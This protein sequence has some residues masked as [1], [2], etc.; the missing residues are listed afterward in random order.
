[1]EQF[2]PNAFMYAEGEE[3][4]EEERQALRQSIEEDQLS[5]DQIEKGEKEAVAAEFPDEGAEV[6]SP[7]GPEAASPTAEVTSQDQ[8]YWWED[9]YDVGDAARNIAQGAVAGQLGALDFA[10]D[11][12]NLIPGVDLPKVPRF[13]NEATQMTR[14]LASFIVPGFIGGGVLPS[15]IKGSAVVKGSKILNNPFTKVVGTMALD[16][17]AGAAIDYTNTLSAEGDNAS[18]MAKKFLQEYYPPAASLIPDNIAT[19]DTDSADDRKR[20]SV[21]E[22]MGLGGAAYFVSGLG[23]LA[24]GASMRVNGNIPEPNFG[25]IVGDSESSQATLDSMRSFPS[26]EATREYYIRNRAESAAKANPNLSPEEIRQTYEEAWSTLSPEI[27]KK[28]SE[29]AAKNDP[30]FVVENLAARQEEALDEVGSYNFSKAQNL[31]EPIFGVHDLY[32]YRESGILTTDELGIISASVDL[33]KVVRNI[34]SVDGSMG[35]V[36]SEA[37]IKYAIAPDAPED[38]QE[39]ILRGLTEQM[40]DVGEYSYIS[41]TGEKITYAE[42]VDDG[43]RLAGQYLGEDIADLQAKFAPMLQAMD[44]YGVRQLTDPGYRAAMDELQNA[45]RNFTDADQLRAQGYIAGSVSKQVSDL[46][47]GVRLMAGTEAVQRGQEQMLDRIQYLMMLTGQTRKARGTALQALDLAKESRSPKTGRR[48][49]TLAERTEMMNAGIREDLAKLKQD[50]TNTIDNLRFLNQTNPEFLDEFVLA[51]EITGGEINTIKKLNDVVNEGTKGILRKGLIDPR[52]EFDSM[53]VKNMWT[54]IYNSMLSAVSTVNK[55]GIGSTTN[56]AALGVGHM[57]GALMTGDKKTLQSALVAYGA[58]WDTLKKGLSYAKDIWRKSASDP[59]VLTPR[60]G[61]FAQPGFEMKLMRQRA[62]RMA[63]N[64]DYGGQIFMNQL[65]EWEAFNNSPWTRLGQRGMGFFDGFTQ[66]VQANWTARIRAH[67]ELTDF[68]ARELQPGQL[69]ELS[70]KVYASMFTKDGKIADEAVKWQAGELNF[71]LDNRAS[72]ALST[73]VRDYPI[74]KP[75]L[76]FQKT[77]MTALGY[78]VDHTPI[79]LFNTELK[80]FSVPFENLTQG[81]VQELLKTK[82]VYTDDPRVM[83]AEYNKFRAITKFRAAAGTTFIASSVGLFMD[84]RLTG[85]GTY[86]SKLNRA[87]RSQGWQPRSVKGPDGKWYSYDGLGALSDL[88][89]LTADVMD[90]GLDGGLS[91]KGMLRN[92]GEHLKALG[93]VVAASLTKKSFTAA[94]EPLTDMTENPA[95]INRWLASFVPAATVPNASMMAEFSRLMYPGLRTVENELGPLL[96]NRTLLKGQLPIEYDWMDGTPINQPQGFWQRVANTYLPFK[97]RKEITPEK[98]FL[99]DVNYSALPAINQRRYTAAQQSEIFRIMGEERLF[100]NAVKRIMKSRSAKDF[101]ARYNEEVARSA[102]T[103]TPYP[104]LQS[105]ENL[106]SMLDTALNESLRN[107][108]MMLKDRDE[109]QQRT[110]RDTVIKNLRKQQRSQERVQNFIDYNRQP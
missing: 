17:G 16:I 94:L 34:D 104:D 27:R 20:K 19:V 35:S 105:L 60:D 107:A 69:K 65:E 71:N 5:I 93:Y 49:A 1:M 59:Y 109:I 33:S 108:E 86:D 63:A 55:A 26:E 57:A 64:G 8:N 100:E 25:R 32:G 67:E 68:G 76:L 43:L 7:E 78:T 2:D 91:G 75:F 58:G 82:G 103:E 62:D 90:N 9:G 4:S 66:A 102:E 37:A 97:S 73:L 83:E 36:M 88:L 77:A 38:V 3:L 74:L 48:Y 13:E 110:Y 87:R 56:L 22:G 15:A 101:R 96:M 23:A 14:D 45:M 51:Y 18:G 106:H 98:Q 31:D 61:Q 52:P 54:S 81:D 70:D 92:P 80:N 12:I 47:Q 30:E 79:G 72:R 95:A 41:T 6:Q 40:K 10:V 11:A 44:Q 50:V 29:V 46:G 53:V 89:A 85:N 24:R 21:F 42:I 99:L 84:D 39:I 28:W